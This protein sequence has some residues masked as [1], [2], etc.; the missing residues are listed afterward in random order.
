MSEGDS[1]D[2]V[3]SRRN[4]IAAIIRAIAWPCVALIAMYY[5][6]DTLDRLVRSTSK[7]SLFGIEIE[8]FVDGTSL[9]SGQLKILEAFTS[10][11]IIDFISRYEGE[12]HY[13]C[14]VSPEPREQDK[15]LLRAGLIKIRDEECSTGSDYSTQLSEEGIAMRRAISRALE[16]AISIMIGK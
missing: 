6:S 11:D 1:F 3:A 12:N 9:N 4:A 16:S 5:F 13:I 7:A 2:A 10:E 15:A 8:K 14:Q